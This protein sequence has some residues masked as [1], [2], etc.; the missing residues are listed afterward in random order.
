MWYAQQQHTQAREQLG[1]IGSDLMTVARGTAMF[2]MAGT[3]ARAG[4]A[5]EGLI[6]PFN[7][8]R[9]AVEDLEA[10]CPL[11]QAADGRWKAQAP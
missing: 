5:L 4:E 9:K 7:R 1:S 2:K 6:R 10:C 8:L 3:K 11:E